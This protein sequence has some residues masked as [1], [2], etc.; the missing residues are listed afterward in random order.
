ME[1]MGC[2][3]FKAAGVACGLKKNGRKDLGL[4]YSE[5]PANVAGLF[6]RN[7][8]QAAPVLLDRQRITAGVCRG[9]HCQQRQCQLLHR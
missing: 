9:R 7:R 3:G 6:T 4:I 8:V 5:L 1:K 2:P